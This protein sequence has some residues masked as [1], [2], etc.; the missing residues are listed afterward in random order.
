MIVSNTSRI[1]N[2]NREGLLDLFKDRL[3]IGEL[4]KV[5]RVLFAKIKK[6]DSVSNPKILTTRDYKYSYQWIEFSKKFNGDSIFVEFLILLDKERTKVQFEGEED[7]NKYIS[8]SWRYVLY[9]QLKPVNIDFSEWK[10]FISGKTVY[11]FS[12]IELQFPQFRGKEGFAFHSDGYNLFLSQIERNGDRLE[13]KKE[14]DEIV[15]FRIVEV[16]S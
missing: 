15:R 4:Y 10:I 9:Q 3:K 1:E 6:L 8:S 16:T 7:I 13:Y 5:N 2:K 12:N 14:S 11:N